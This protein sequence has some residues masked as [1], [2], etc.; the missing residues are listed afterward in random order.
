VL[1][2]HFEGCFFFNFISYSFILVLLYS[3]FYACS[4]AWTW[5]R[6]SG[7]L[8]GNYQVFSLYCLPLIYSLLTVKIV[9]FTE[10]GAN[11]T[12]ESLMEPLERLSAPLDTVWGVAKTLYV[13]DNQVMP[14]EV[15]HKIHNRAFKARSMKYQSRPIYEACKVFN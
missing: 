11:I 6:E 2:C 7:E 5:N 4:S 12:F 1:Q 13:T 3:F 9:F 10:P 8:R 15:Y 14:S